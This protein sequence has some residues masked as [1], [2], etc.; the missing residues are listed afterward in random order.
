MSLPA[1]DVGSARLA[2]GG[3][4]VLSLADA[5]R[6]RLRTWYESGEHKSE[7]RL[8]PDLECCDSWEEVVGLGVVRVPGVPMAG[9]G[10]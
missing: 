5:A 1:T 6:L 10:R 7:R 8:I 4:A 2:L 3:A 9:G